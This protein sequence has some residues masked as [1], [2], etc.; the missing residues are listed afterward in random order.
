MHP[1]CS[2]LVC[3]LS[4]EESQQKSEPKMFLKE[5]IPYWVEEIYFEVLQAIQKMYWKDKEIIFFI[6]GIW[7]YFMCLWIKL[8]DYFQMFLILKMKM[9][10][11]LKFVENISITVE[12]FVNTQMK[13]SNIKCIASCTKVWLMI[14]NKYLKNLSVDTNTE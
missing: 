9:L 6:K 3:F 10:A 12:W 2:T 11:W 8:N 13:I 4:F 1:H 5:Q 14:L 7:L